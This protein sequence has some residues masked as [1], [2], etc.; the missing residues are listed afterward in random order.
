MPQ[1]IMTESY[2]KSSIFINKKMPSY[3]ILVIMEIISMMNRRSPMAEIKE[4]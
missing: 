3:Y 4:R 1:G 2:K